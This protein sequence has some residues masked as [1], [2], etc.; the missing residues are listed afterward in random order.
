[1]TKS[2]NESI[3]RSNRKRKQKLS[4]SD[5]VAARAIKC[6]TLGDLS[7]AIAH[8]QSAQLDMDSKELQAVI[9]FAEMSEGA[10]VAFLLY[11]S[12]LGLDPC[13]KVT[14]SETTSTVRSTKRF[15]A[16]TGIAFEV[17]VGTD[18]LDAARQCMP[19]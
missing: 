14:R 8:M 12:G 1:M 6:L 15:E 16:R 19:F 7:F 3:P 5:A 18:R 4:A 17:Q 9:Q 13:T 11:I 10:D 2:Q